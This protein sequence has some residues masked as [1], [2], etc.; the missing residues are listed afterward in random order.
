MRR[1][2]SLMRR[3]VENT[4]DGLLTLDRDGAIRSVNPAAERILR[5]KGADL[6]ERPFSSLSR[7]C[8]SRR[9]PTG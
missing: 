4:F 1:S 3:V 9:A 5:R 8:R 7:P 2:N 6:M